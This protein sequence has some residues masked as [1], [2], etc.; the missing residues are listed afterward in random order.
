M[1]PLQASHA[2]RVTAVSGAPG[3]EVKRVL[4]GYAYPQ[5]G[6]VHNPTP[7]Y[8]WLLM[9]DGHV[10]DSDTKRGPLV[11]AAYQPDA[12]KKYSEGE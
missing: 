10:V 8:S 12:R 11:A 6:N 1:D 2:D 9:L 4:A 7:V 3:F 5:N